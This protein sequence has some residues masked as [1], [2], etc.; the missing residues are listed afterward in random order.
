MQSSRP[1]R[2]WTRCCSRGSSYIT[3]N[4]VPEA[5]AFLTAKCLPFR[6][7]LS[8]IY[9]TVTW[10]NSSLEQFGQLA[11]VATTIANNIK[12]VVA[13]QIQPGWPRR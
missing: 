1:S 2:S 9:D 12:D 3:K 5:V 8:A 11:G 13:G 7:R 6:S 10:L 4:V